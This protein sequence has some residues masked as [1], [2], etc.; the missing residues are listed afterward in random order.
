MKKVAALTFSALMVA[1]LLLYT[2]K[3][4]G[5]SCPDAPRNTFYSANFFRAEAFFQD[6]AVN[7]AGGGSTI[8]DAGVPIGG[9]ANYS[10]H[11][12]ESKSLTESQAYTFIQQELKA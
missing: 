4:Q 11:L 5:Q 3:T 9:D 10:Q 2:E 6:K 12:Q 8:S 1:Y 7:A